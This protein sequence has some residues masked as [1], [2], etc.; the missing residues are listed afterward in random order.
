MAGYTRQ[1]A[2]SIVDGLT[3]TASV[4]NNEFNQIQTAFNANTG[5]T[6]LPESQ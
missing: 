4:F 3:I 6:I 5:L 1:S 2:S